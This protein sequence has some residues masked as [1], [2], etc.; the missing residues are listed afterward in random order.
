[1]CRALLIESPPSAVGEKKSESSVEIKSPLDVSDQSH[2]PPSGNYLCTFQLAAQALQLNIGI[3]KNV[4]SGPNYAEEHD[5]TVAN[6]LK[7]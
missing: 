6:T 7:Y 1:M 5:S 3:G 2:D 4:K